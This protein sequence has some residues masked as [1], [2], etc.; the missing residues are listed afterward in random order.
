MAFAGIS[1]LAIGVAAIVAFVFGAVWYGALGKVW[2]AAQGKTGPQMKAS[3]MPVG[4][5][6]TSFVGLLV[7]A[8]VLAG[9][10]G[11]LG[12][13]HVTIRAGAISG[14]FCWL[15]FVI[16]TLAA[17]HA[18]QGQKRTLT[19]IDGGHWLGVLLIEGAVIGAFGV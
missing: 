8:W 3:A 14:A 1:Y 2:M 18:F 15:G 12:P 9:L 11:H 7:M 13:G 19:A 17:N 6:V 4:P 5:M 16:T 10:V